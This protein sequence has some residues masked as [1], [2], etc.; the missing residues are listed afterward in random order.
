MLKEKAHESFYLLNNKTRY[1]KEKNPK[2]DTHSIKKRERR[3]LHEVF[4]ACRKK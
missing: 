1:F 2:G 3:K 4:K